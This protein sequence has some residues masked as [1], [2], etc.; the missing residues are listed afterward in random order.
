[1]DR[2]DRNQAQQMLGFCDDFGA[3]VLLSNF[4]EDNAGYPHGTHSKRTMST[5]TYDE[6]QQNSIRYYHPFLWLLPIV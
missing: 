4:K 2:E 6:I 1:M 3:G 5:S